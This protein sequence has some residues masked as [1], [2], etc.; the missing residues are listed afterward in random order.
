MLLA[1]ERGMRSIVFD[2]RHGYLSLSNSARAGTL[3][4]ASAHVVNRA[5]RWTPV[6]LGACVLGP[7]RA[8]QPVR[9]PALARLDGKIYLHQPSFGSV[10]EHSLCQLERASQWFVPRDRALK[11]CSGA[12]CRRL[13][14]TAVQAW[15]GQLFT[16]AGAGPNV[17]ASADGGQGWHAL[18]GSVD[19]VDRVDRVDN[20]AC[21]HA[22]FR[23][24]D[25]RLLTGGACP[26]GAA[27]RAYQ[28]APDGVSLAS[29]EPLPV[30]LP[31]LENRNVQFIGP[32]GRALFA[33]LEGALLRSTDGARSFQFVMHYPRAGAHY[34][35]IGSL[36]GLRNRPDV[37][38]AAGADQ[39]SG[40]P[41][42]AVSRD[43]GG[44]WT[45]LSASLP[46][47]DR[48][49]LAGAAQVTSLIED[50]LGRILLTLNLEPQS[51]G[52]LVLL[53]LD[54]VD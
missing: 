36:L 29:G 51:R 40:R 11:L 39:A 35:T 44:R 45:D 22:P 16:N 2:A 54:G 10:R 33:G 13:W 19:R 41:Y 43:G 49:G 38:L 4:L 20:S 3:V 7:A 46:G 18:L 12:Q 25:Q 31:D 8:G 14:M 5:S 15:R 24:V 23:I 34:P 30:T 42:L 47:Y 9:A 52:H 32:A 6:E 53:T 1:T 37:L 28:M 26:P 50:P 27:L 17:L 21:P 48:S